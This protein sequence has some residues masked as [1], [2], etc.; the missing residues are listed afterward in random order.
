M[1]LHCRN[2]NDALKEGF[3][4]LRVTGVIESSRNGPV[5]VA[6]GPVITEY[7]NPCERVLFNPRRDANPVFHLMEALWMIAGSDD[8]SFLLPFNSRFEEYAESD[9]VVWGAYG[10]RWRSAFG[11]EQIRHTAQ[12]LK[13]SP[14]SRQAVMQMWDCRLDLGQVKKDIPCNTHIYFDCR[15]GELNMTVCCRSNDILWGAYGANA[16]HMS[17]L[18][19]V[20]ASMIGAPVGVY[21]Q[22]SNNFHA[23]LDNE[24]TQHFLEYGARNHDQYPEVLRVPLIGA[25]EN[26]DWFIEDCEALVAGSN[27]YCTKFFRQVAIPL[28]NAYLSRTSSKTPIDKNNFSEEQRNIDWIVAFLQWCERRKK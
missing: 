1:I 23:Y 26:A 18:Q 13:R 5:M 6:P 24:T 11:I 28:Y 27:E 25:D 9:G 21:R 22:F 15:G 16:V 14:N 3:E 17:V 7:A 10:R 19:E 2:V 4:W 8:V 20:M 12:V